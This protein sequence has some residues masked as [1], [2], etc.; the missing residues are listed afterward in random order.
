VIKALTDKGVYE[1]NTG[2]YIETFSLTKGQE[3]E[4]D[5]FEY[6]VKRR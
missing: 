4:Y 5:R 2:G 6:A 1:K 3:Y